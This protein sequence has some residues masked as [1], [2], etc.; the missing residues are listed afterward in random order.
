M[1]KPRN[2]NQHLLIAPRKHNL[3]EVARVKVLI[4]TKIAV[5][6]HLLD[7]QSLL[8]KRAKKEIFAAQRLSRLYPQKV[9][10]SV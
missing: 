8:S 5:T 1:S 2:R 3:R 10:R 9:L 6:R 4:E 7:V